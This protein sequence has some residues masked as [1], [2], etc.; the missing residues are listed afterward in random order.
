MCRRWL[1]L[2][3]LLA[4]VGLLELGLRTFVPAPA[5]GSAARFELDPDLIYRLQ[6]RNE[7]SWSSAE[8]TETSHTNALGMRGAA[9]IPPQRPGE[10][11]ILAVGDSFTYGHGVQDDETY[12]AVLERLLRERGHDVRVL[13]AGVPGYSTDQEYTYV[14]RD[15]LKLAPDLVLLGIHCSDVSDN[16][17]SSLYD[18]ADGRLIRRGAGSTRMYQLGSVVGAIPPWVRRSRTFELLVAAFDWHDS[19]RERPAV[20]DLDAWSYEKMR[21]EVIDMQTR[22]AAVGARLAVVLMP[23][24]KT[25]G[26]GAPDPYGPLARDLTAAG[27]PLLESAPL[28]RRAFPDLTPLFFRDDPHL[29]PRGDR[30]LAHVIAAFLQERNLLA[31]APRT[32]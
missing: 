20:A 18:V 15:G 29:N 27:V 6:P 2:G 23:C 3:S 9:D 31:V 13:N 12:P 10:I 4:G 28:L 22:A 21:L 11:R 30:E 24:K 1:L 8:F 5:A 17:E 16:Y 7:V 25:L 14:L 32:Y 19:A 26:T